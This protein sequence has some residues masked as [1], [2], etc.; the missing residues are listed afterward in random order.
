MS[1]PARPASST[2]AVIAPGPA[3][4]GIASGKAAMSRTCSS[5]ALPAVS[6]W[7]VMRTSNA[8][9]LAIE[10]SK[11]PPAI[12]QAGSE[13][14]SV[15]SSQS[16]AS[17]APV[18]I[19][20]AM[21]QARIATLRR[22]ADGRPAVM[23]R[24]AGVNPIGSTTTSSGTRAKIR[25]SSG[26]AIGCARIWVAGWEISTT[27]KRAAATAGYGDGREGRCVRLVEGRG[28]IRCA[29]V[30]GIGRLLAQSNPWV[31]DA[32]Q[33]P[34]RGLDV[35]DSK[36]HE[37]CD[38]ASADRSEIVVGAHEA[39]LHFVWIRR[40]TAVSLMVRQRP[41]VA[42]N[43]GNTS[44]P[45]L[46]FGDQPYGA[47]PDVEIQVVLD[48]EGDPDR[49]PALAALLLKKSNR[50]VDVR[51]VVGARKRPAGEPECGRHQHDEHGKKRQ[52]SRGSH[53]NIDDGEPDTCRRHCL[54]PPDEIEA[55][56][57]DHVHA[58]LEIEDDR[59]GPSYEY[60]EG[61]SRD[62]VPAIVRRRPHRTSQEAGK[63]RD[64][65]YT[66]KLPIRKQDVKNRNPAL[67]RLLSREFDVFS[68]LS[69][70][71]LQHVQDN[72]QEKYRQDDNAGDH[73]AAM[74]GN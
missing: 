63:E 66:G 29:A 12:R 3:I 39:D 41:V 69:G 70:K 48:V 26:N 50:V 74:L 53:P 35:I 10:N 18:R 71:M 56:V 46:L 6:D 55:V 64:G 23:P 5:I 47:R 33:R 32:V 59:S 68:E 58:F 31:A 52:A 20:N 22:A 44:T 72:G 73:A 4:S 65:R 8:I 14:E 16:P 2:V 36:A 13:M 28:R 51:E 25:K 11:S 67:P 21:R 37:S 49:P 7:R 34:V 1:P 45:S 38:H 43:A 42:L 9:S 19:P 15:R 60:R 54:I 62:G 57:G 40:R 61:R 27:H 24:K 30:R 17:A